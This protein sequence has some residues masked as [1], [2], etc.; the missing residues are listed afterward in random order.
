MRME[1]S[2][3]LVA[4]AIAASNSNDYSAAALKSSSSS[5]F[6][7]GHAKL[8]HQTP[9]RGRNMYSSTVSLESLSS[10]NL[11]YPKTPSITPNS[12]YGLLLRFA[13]LPR[14]GARVHRPGEC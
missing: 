3:L 1:M 6:G 2:F 5:S 14:T 8:Q 13:P 10:Y 7:R 9:F 12:H 4:A 11:T